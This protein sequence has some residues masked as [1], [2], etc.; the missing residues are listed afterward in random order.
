[1]TS[2][3]AHTQVCYRVTTHDI[4]FIFLH[5][6]SKPTQK[7]LDLQRAGLSALLSR[8][9]WH[10]TYTRLLSRRWGDDGNYVDFGGRH[11]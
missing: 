7:L 9:L 10:G 5:A 8:L 11:D 3:V 6:L 2:E 4:A 1:M